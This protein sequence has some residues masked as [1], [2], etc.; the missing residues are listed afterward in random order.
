VQTAS[1]TD[2]VKRL[3]EVGEAKNS[4]EFVTFF[5]KNA[6]YRFGNAESAIGRTAIRDAVA[7]FFPLIKSLYHDIQ[8]TWEQ[9]NLLLVEMNV[10]YTR[11][12][13]KVVTIPVADTFR[14]EGGLIKDMRIYA[15][16]TPVLA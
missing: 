13:G 4:D 9:G 8:G 7:N 3:F 5:T 10:I 16:T 12:D 14:F 15:D 6:E 2:V 1:M 11:H